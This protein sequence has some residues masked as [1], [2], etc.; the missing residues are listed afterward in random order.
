MQ[1]IRKITYFGTGILLV[2]LGLALS[3]CRE[4][5]WNNPHK[6]PATANYYYGTFASS[7]KTLDPARSYSSDEATFT[8]QI[9]EPPLQYHFLLRPYTLIP[10][11]T[12]AMP[13]VHYW[14]TQDRLLPDNAPASQVAYTTYDIHIKPG[15]YYQP[16]PALAR[17]LNGQYLYHDL[18][19]NDLRHKHQLSD[20]SKNGTRELVAADYVYEIKRLASPRVNSPIL[21]VM[22]KKIVGLGEYAKTLQKIYIQQLQKN[23]QQAFLDLRLYDFAGAK[24]LDRYSYRITIHSKDP[25][26]LF[27]LSMPFFAPIPWE[28]DYFYSQ[29]GMEAKNFTFDWYPIGTGAYLLSENNPNQQMVLAKN[30]NFHGEFFPTEGEPNDKEHGYLDLAGKPLPFIDQYIFRLEKETIPRWNKFLQGYYDQS[31]ISSDNFDQ[32]VHITPDGRPQLTPS[33]Q[34]KGIYLQT[35]VG[36][37]LFYFGFNMLDNTV[38]GYSE[39]ARK[40]RQ[41]IAIG[42]DTEEFI[43]IFLNGRGIVAQGPIPP[44]IFGHI[45]GGAGIDPYIY[46]W[47]ENRP[48]RKSLAVARRLLAEAGYPNGRDIKTGAPLILNFDTAASS[49]PDDK[50][51]FDWLR[52][53]FAKLNIQLNIRATQ[54]NRFQEIM[55]TGDAQIFFWGW[56]ADYPDPEN[57]LFLFYGPNGKVKS[58]GENATNYQ[59]SAFDRLFEQM[60]TMP[61]NAQRLA[62]IEKMVNILQLDAPAIWGFFPK[63]Y[64]LNQ[65]WMQP[66]KPSAIANNTLKYQRLNPLLRAQLQREWNQPK[67]LPLFFIALAV[68]LLLFIIGGLSY[69]LQHKPRSK[70][71]G[72]DNLK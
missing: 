30:P 39:R 8:A 4:N 12:N 59:N 5:S 56:L 35:S 64:I 55:R 60:E 27:W 37:S 6:T 23:P 52:K 72:N 29:P 42:F 18:K 67:R 14:N 24:I 11:T 20:F 66:S 46:D 36:P 17:D 19:P 71:Y 10:L 21:S 38:G 15:I 16:H 47:H 45:K 62:I 48:E 43:A 3:A 2:L 9:Y 1:L 70:R 32:A 44:G 33:M 57:F 41:A 53:Q 54:Y 26:F 31:G 68:V 22:S 34:K 69:R 40:L 51:R 63:S 25:Q 61:N 49:A 65:Q 7:P 13:I 50:A 58:D 28:A